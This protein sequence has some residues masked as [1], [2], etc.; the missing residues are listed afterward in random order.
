MFLIPP[1]HPRRRGFQC[2]STKR[3]AWVSRRGF[4]IVEL[5]VTITIAAILTGLLMPALRAVR[6]S[7][8]GIVCNSQLRQIGIAS[9]V[10]GLFNNESLPATRFDD[11]D[12]NRPAELM[13]MTTGAMAQPEQSWQWDGLGL[14]I[15]D[16]GRYLDDP[17]VMYCPC[18]HGEHHFSVYAGQMTKDF[19]TRIYSN[20]HYIGDDD[21]TTGK[22][23]LLYEQ[24]SE[25]VLVVDGMRSD[26]DVNHVSGT[27]ILR[28]D[29]SVRFWYDRSFALRNAFANCSTDSPPPPLTYQQ[30]WA[31]FAA[32]P[33]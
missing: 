3:A 21:Q 30:L 23:R 32:D 16:P 4:T 27:N 10:Y 15:G 7:G 26:T 12:N 5:I 22:R 18:H 11:V 24:T 33:H 13:A 25:T 2:S 31:L 29:V 8:N 28:G 19:A 20:Y 14:L 1:E 6:A 17:R 9:H